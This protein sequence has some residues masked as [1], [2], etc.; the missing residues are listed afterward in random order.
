PGN[1]ELWATVPNAGTAVH[2]T[3]DG[4]DDEFFL[5]NGREGLGG[6]A[7]SEDESTLYVV[8]LN[9][10]LLYSYNTADAAPA[11]PVSSVPITDPGCVGGDWR[12]FSVT[13][14]DGEV[15]VGGVCDASSSLLRSDL[16]AHV[17]QL[18]GGTFT[19]I[20]SKTLDFPRGGEGHPDPDPNPVGEDVSTH[21]NPWR[22][23][24]DADLADYFADGPLYPTPML[25]S[26]V[27]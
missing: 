13:V 21:W 8:N 17:V 7:L 26:V 12:P 25:T 16:A 14:R 20:Y 10:R 6:V 24:W 22:E 27:F 9:D 2:Q 4:Y 1:T 23:T 3:D 18:D 11:S 15:Y 5:A 19:S